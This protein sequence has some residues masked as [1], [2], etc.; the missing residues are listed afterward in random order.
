[1]FDA[2]TGEFLF[3][4]ADFSNKISLFRIF[5]EAA[6]PGIDHNIVS[7]LKPHYSNGI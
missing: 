4:L 5:I 6:N 1:M 2:N 7:I 3:V